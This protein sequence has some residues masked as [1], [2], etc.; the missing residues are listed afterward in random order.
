MTDSLKGVLGELRFSGTMEKGSVPPEDPLQPGESSCGVVRRPLDIA[1][2]V[3][4]SLRVKEPGPI[5]TVKEGCSRLTCYPFLF[6]L[7]K[8]TVSLQNSHIFVSEHFPF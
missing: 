3:Q 7:S 2:A 4:S 8:Y 1:E 6:P 5:L